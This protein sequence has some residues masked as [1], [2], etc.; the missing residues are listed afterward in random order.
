MKTGLKLPLQ[1]YLPVACLPVPVDWACEVHD[2]AIRMHPNVGFFPKNARWL[3]SAMVHGKR[4]KLPGGAGSHL[5]LREQAGLFSQH[6]NPRE[7]N[8]F[9]PGHGVIGYISVNKRDYREGQLQ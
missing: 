5:E 2:C 3:L 9:S 7:S 8:G 1:K 6:L 4:E